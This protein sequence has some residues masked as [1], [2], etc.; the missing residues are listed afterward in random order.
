M[1]KL[2]VSYSH[3]DESKVTNFIKYMAPLTGGDNPVLEIWYDREI[4]AGDDFWDRI[5]E[6]LENRD[7]ISIFRIM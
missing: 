7:V 6:H 1:M 3:A 2:F 5:N 4:K